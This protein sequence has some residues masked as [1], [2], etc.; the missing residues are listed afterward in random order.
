[1]IA[2]DLRCSSAH[3]FEGWFASSDAY[4]AQQGSGLLC[5]P[6]CGDG[7]ITKAPSA[8][9]I[10]RKSNQSRKGKQSSGAESLES[11]VQNVDTMS[12]ALPVSNAPQIP[13]AMTHLIEKLASAQAEVLKKSEWVGNKF[14]DEARAIHYGETQA[15][16]IHGEASLKEA[17]ALSEEGVGIAALPLPFIP[18]EAKN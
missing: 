7:L 8:P 4:D 16:Q 2:Y 5:C 15:R 11:N 6:M 10:P 9:F 13:E 17:E 1:M 12:S 14:A 18:P 3:I